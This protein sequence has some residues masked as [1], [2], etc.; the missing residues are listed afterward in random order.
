MWSCSC[1]IPHIVQL[2]LRKNRNGPIGDIHLKWTG[3]TTTFKALTKEEYD[4]AREQAKRAAEEY[5][6]GESE[7]AA[8]AAPAPE[9]AVSVTEA[10]DAPREEGRNELRKLSP[11][12]DPF[13]SAGGKPAEENAFE[14]E[15]TEAGG[16][17][18]TENGSES[19]LPP[20]DT[21]NE[22]PEGGLP[23]FDAFD[24][25]ITEDLPFDA[26]AP[27]DDD[28]CRRRRRR[29]YLRRRGVKF[30]VKEDK[31]DPRQTPRVCFLP[32]LYTISAP[33]YTHVSD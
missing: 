10:A 28:V 4:A 15:A 30:S 21:D 11:E 19:D 18:E 22:S 9:A 13:V 8:A 7:K 31:R 2:L 23:A 29:R 1:T 25:E 26:P 3:E 24:G 14:E 12:D 17:F 16:V 6:H 20:F 33:R 5:V 32:D 27:T